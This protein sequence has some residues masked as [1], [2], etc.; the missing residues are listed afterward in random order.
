MMLVAM[1][2]ALGGWYVIYEQ[3]KFLGK[4]HNTSWHSW[5]GLLAIGGYAV[6]G[7][8]G[9]SALHPDFGRCNK[10]PRVRLAHKL[11]SRASTVAALAATATGVAKSADTLPS[12]L[13][14]VALL[15][16]ASVLALFERPKWS[17]SSASGSGSLPPS[18]QVDDTKPIFECAAARRKRERCGAPMRGVQ[19]D[20][21]R[22][23]VRVR[24]EDRNS[25]EEALGSLHRSV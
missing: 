25:R 10:N 17:A 2:L 3:K 8:V 7:A 19:A 23:R 16:L 22:S 11:F 20:S 9:L 13:V 1:S 14:L 6:G 5:Q 12:V 24:S 18:S 15:A 21:D 4:P